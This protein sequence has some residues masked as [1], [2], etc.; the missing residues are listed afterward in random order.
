MTIFGW[1]ASDFD[2]DR[3]P[4]DLAAARRDGIEFF[5]HKATESVNVKHKHY[6][7][8]LNR[9]RSAGIPFLG[10]YHVVRSSA[11]SKS[12][13]DYLLAYVNAATPW[14]K[15]FPGWFFQVDLEKW[16]YDDVSAGKGEEFADIL[17]QRTGRKAVIYA[18]KGQYGDA[19]RDTS[20]PLWNANYGNNAS[21]WY[22]Q[23]YTDRGGDEGSGWASYSGVAPAIWQY[24]SNAVIGSQ[25]TCDANAFR[26]TTKDFAR[27]IGGSVTLSGD[28]EK[29]FLAKDANGTLYLC[30]GMYSRVL[31][32]KGD[33]QTLINEGLIAK[34]E[35]WDNPRAG[36][37]E[38]AFGVVLTEKATAQSAV[39]SVDWAKLA[40]TIATKVADALP[41][42]I[43]TDT[44]VAAF[45]TADVQAIL[46]EQAFQGSQEAE[47][48]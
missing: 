43:S 46:K 29:M 21:K 36:F 14:W 38:G 26:G 1:D 42:E 6:A 3:G 44:V 15:D 39:A 25:H 30:N 45:N 19:L 8:A 18:S 27:L 33:M 22:H 7:D 9:A 31:A 11:S 24:G 47:T 5:T 40:D 28:E 23:L 13:V 4:M 48:K 32:N 17:E 16:S 10:A 41:A 12:Q 20:H 37:F 34:P 35:S 2:W